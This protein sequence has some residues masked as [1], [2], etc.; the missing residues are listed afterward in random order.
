M[1]WLDQALAY[2]VLQEK[3]IKLKSILRFFSLDH[4]GW[5]RK[6]YDSYTLHFFVSAP[7]EEVQNDY[8]RQTKYGIFYKANHIFLPICNRKLVTTFSSTLNRA[9]ILC[10]KCEMCLSSI[11]KAQK[12]LLENSVL[13]IPKGEKYTFRMENRRKN[14]RTN[15]ERN[16]RKS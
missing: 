9:S 10:F 16:I 14:G 15:M 11:R 1:H 13:L 5:K 8:I 12:I 3:D 6:G 4:L 2:K 7:K